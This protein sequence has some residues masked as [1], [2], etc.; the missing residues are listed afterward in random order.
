VCAQK[1]ED[2]G[3]T[4]LADGIRI[5]KIRDEEAYE[6][7][8]VVLEARLANARIP[9]QIDVGFGDVVTPAPTGKSSKL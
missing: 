6:G 3:V 8:R 9:L 1:V 7:I 5:E 2:D 4:F